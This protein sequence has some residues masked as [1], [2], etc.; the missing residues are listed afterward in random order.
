MVESTLWLR[1]LILNYPAF[2]YFLIFF[3]SALGGD[4][5]LVAFGFLAAQGVISPVTLVFFG[6]MG[7]YCSD[8]FLFLLAR[9]K[10]LHN[11]ITHRYAHKTVSLI[12]DSLRRV[13]HGNHFLALVIAK[14]LVGTRVVIVL[15]SDRTDL[16]LKKFIYYDAVAAI[17]WLITVIPIGFFLG[18]GFTYLS[19]VFKNIYA[20]IGL[21]LLF[22]VAGFMLEIWL[23]KIFTRVPEDNT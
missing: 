2:Q 20:G 17:I 6:F 23:R 11:I 21:V 12:V 15:Y 5:I 10:F 13:S 22:I 19:E 4:F 14:F 16:A 18:L 9:T 3:G 1:E 8:I 7:T